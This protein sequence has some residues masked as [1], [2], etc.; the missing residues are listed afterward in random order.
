MSIMIPIKGDV[1][2]RAVG[3]TSEGRRKAAQHRH[4]T[5]SFSE[6]LYGGT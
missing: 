2:S 1:R 4:I 5:G 6:N 3:E